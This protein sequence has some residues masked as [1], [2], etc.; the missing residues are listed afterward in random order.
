[1]KIYFMKQ[2]ALDYI[3]INI[4]SLYKYYYQFDSPE[5]IYE[6]F[7]YDPFD[8]FDD[9]E[10]FEL[11][12]LD[13]QPG[14]I[15][16][17]N[18]KILY[19]KL[20][21]ITD[22][23]ASDERLWAGLTNKTF[24]S[25]MRK[26]WKYGRRHLKKTADDSSAIL[27]RYFYK[28]SGRGGMYRNTLA[29]CWW[30]GRLT[31][32]EKNSN[33]WELLDAI[34]PED[35]ISKISDIFYSNTYSSNSD[36]L[37]GFCQGLKFFRD[38]NIYVSTR[39]HIRPTAQYLNAIGGGLL[40]DMFTAEEIRN[41]V[42]ERLGTLIKGVDPGLIAEIYEDPDEK[43]DIEDVENTV[44]VEEVNIDFGE[45][46]DS[47]EQITELD[48]DQ[49]LGKLTEVEYGCK[50]HIRKMPENNFFISKMPMIDG[51]LNMLQ[52]WFLGK[53]IGS[54]WKLGGSTYEII[55]IRRQ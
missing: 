5:W 40:L 2:S 28:N 55:D 44:D 24:Y 26:R 18:C 20:K 54:T 12:S 23:Q 27:M 15:D 36:V 19:S 31:Y 25:Y 1:M 45:Y 6:L 29:R 33:H 34:G 21:H 32:S 47:L 4:G 37:E 43:L 35:I 30:V 10:D 22:S 48:I 42:I 16:L 49:V 14:E 41:M 52:K 8:V 3:K 50:I 39:E 17:Q 7:D 53:P 13:Q 11:A 46:I 51:E 9:V 38:R